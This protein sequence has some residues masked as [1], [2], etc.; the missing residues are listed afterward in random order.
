MILYTRADWESQ[1][2]YRKKAHWVDGRLL[3]NETEGCLSKLLNKASS[4]TPPSNYARLKSLSSGEHSFHLKCHVSNCTLHQIVLNG[5]QTNF[6]VGPTFSLVAPYSLFTPYS[7]ASNLSF[8]LLHIWTPLQV[9]YWERGESRD[10]KVEHGT[11][12]LGASKSRTE[13][14]EDL[15]CTIFRE[16]SQTFRMI[17]QLYIIWLFDDSSYT[18]SWHV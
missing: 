7:Q 5:I 16:V 11:E 4:T 18:C 14:M 6:N 1:H 8:S 3:S 15:L 12:E 9:G 10:G 2:D 17:G 13:F